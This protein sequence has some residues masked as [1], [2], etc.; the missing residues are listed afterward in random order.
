M[1]SYQ[2]PQDEGYSEDPLTMQLSGATR[3][4]VMEAEV[5]EWL[6]D[7]PVPERARKS[8]PLDTAA[9]LQLRHCLHFCD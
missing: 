3:R 1:A 5:Q 9:G 6:S 2:T 4:T 8:T 7:L